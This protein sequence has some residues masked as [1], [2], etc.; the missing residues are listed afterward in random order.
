[1]VNRDALL[2][3][4]R[5]SIMRFQKLLKTHLTD[6]EHDYIKERLSACRVA[7]KA[8]VESSNRKQSGNEKGQP[9]HATKNFP[10]AV[11]HRTTTKSAQKDIQKT[12]N[13]CFLP[14]DE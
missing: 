12:F 1:M 13:V 6:E 7:V 4:Y 9:L 10:N 3:A 8:L 5:G 2:S 11:L 14:P